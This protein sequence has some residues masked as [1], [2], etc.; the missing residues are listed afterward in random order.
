MLKEGNKGGRELGNKESST[1]SMEGEGSSQAPQTKAKA[2]ELDLE[3]LDHFRSFRAVNDDLVKQIMK[4][5]LN[6]VELAQKRKSF[7]DKPSS[8]PD[9]AAG[10]N[11]EAGNKAA[12]KEKKSQDNKKVKGKAS[13]P[14][15]LGRHRV[16]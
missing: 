8:Q 6:E 2:P 12:S 16:M 3:S 7:Y 10:T 9:P 15:Y 5:D 14:S 4:I 1:M 13:S 11:S